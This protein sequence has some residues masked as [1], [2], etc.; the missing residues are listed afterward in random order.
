MKI[1]RKVSQKNRVQIPMQLMDE[2]NIQE[3][4]MVL[5]DINKNKITLEKEVSN[6]SI[7]SK[8]IY[9]SSKE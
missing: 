1:K 9:K 8:K 6:D 2:L 4:D 7:Y 3:G 5:F